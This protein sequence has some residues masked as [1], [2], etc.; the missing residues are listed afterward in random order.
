MHRRW[1]RRRPR[2]CTGVTDAYL[3]SLAE[4]RVNAKCRLNLEDTV[5]HKRKREQL[6]LA[7]GYGRAHDR[8]ADRRYN[9]EPNQKDVGR[10]SADGH[11]VSE[12]GSHAPCHACAAATR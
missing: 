5:E 9:D 4:G 11:N 6:L 3:V 12:E 10:H 8:V 1:R 2:A 7:C